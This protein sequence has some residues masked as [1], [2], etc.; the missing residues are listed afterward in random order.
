M[1]GPGAFARRCLSRAGGRGAML[2]ALMLGAAPAATA[3]G[4]TSGAPGRAID[5]DF[6]NRSQPT[7]CAEE[8]N[9]DVRVMAAGATRFSVS[10]EHPPY[11]SLVGSDSTAPDFSHCNMSGDPAHAF[12]PRTT[13]LFENDSIRLVGHTF[14]SFWRPEVVDFMVGGRTE[15]GLHLVQLL[16][17]GV[18]SPPPEDLL[19]MRT[20]LAGRPAEPGLRDVEILVVY[21]SDGY[22]RAKPLPPAQM[23]DSAYGSSFMVGPIEED[24]RPIVR[25]RSI[26][27]EPGD[28]SFHL[29]FA[30]GLKGVLRV[31][32][33]TRSRVRL[34]VELSQGLS[35][36]TSI[37]ALRSMFVTTDNADASVAIS[38]L[39]DQRGMRHQ[40]LLEFDR[41]RSPWAR[42]GRTQPS[43]H[44]LSAPDMVFSDFR[45]LQ[46]WS[47][48]R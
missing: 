1:K 4:A 20:A 39:P 17:K 21:P 32:D 27:F 28:L 34:D 5:A 29:E 12:Q 10:A 26:R 46:E 44:N 22:W 48:A 42:F 7:R 16:R 33:A 24:G 37:A 14:S 2:V 38:P 36:K 23:A 18:A 35:P 15:R 8:D 43:T 41:F 45:T 47:T 19:R 25:F 13:V 11:V 9:I 30:A 3:A 6:I 31:A 40:P